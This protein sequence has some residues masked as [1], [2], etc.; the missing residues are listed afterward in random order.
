M[1]NTKLKS[2]RRKKHRFKVQKGAVAV[3]YNK[4]YRI[5]PIIDISESGLSFRYIDNNQEQTDIFRLG[6]FFRDKVFYLRL[7]PVNVIYTIM[8]QNNVSY[9]TLHMIRCGVKFMQLSNYHSI[10]LR[11]FIQNFTIDI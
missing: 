2:E 4:R 7:L 9:I 3:L 6:I 10:L 8:E 1:I 11:N 5:G